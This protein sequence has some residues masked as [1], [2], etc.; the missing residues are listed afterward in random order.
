[1]AKNNSGMAIKDRSIFPEY[2]KKINRKSRG[3]L[4]SVIKLAIIVT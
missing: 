4:Q 2:K 1:M 3:I